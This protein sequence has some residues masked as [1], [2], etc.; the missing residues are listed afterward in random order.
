MK[1]RRDE[2]STSEGC[3]GACEQQETGDRIY[4]YNIRVHTCMNGASARHGANNL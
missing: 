2:E 3:K 1:E 4:D